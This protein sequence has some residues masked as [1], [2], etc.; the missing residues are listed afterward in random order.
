[1]EMFENTS[2]NASPSDITVSSSAK[3]ETTKNL[4]KRLESKGVT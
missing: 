4:L 1:M 3:L 2:K